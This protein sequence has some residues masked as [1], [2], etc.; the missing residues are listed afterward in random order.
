MPARQILPKSPKIPLCA[1]IVLSIALV[2]VL[3]VA[4]CDSQDFP[5]PNHEVVIGKIN[6]SGSQEWLITINDSIDNLASDVIQLPDENIAVA[7]STRNIE[8]MHLKGCNQH[9]RLIVI[10]KNGVQIVDEKET[11]EGYRSFTPYFIKSPQN[12]EIMFYESGIIWIFN[13]DSGK[14]LRRLQ[15]NRSIYSIFS[16]SENQYIG[17]SSTTV[18]KIDTNLNTVWKMSSVNQSIDTIQSVVEMSDKRGYLISG[19][20]RDENI[21]LTLYLLRLD[22]HGN[23]SSKTKV[24]NIE[25]FLWTTS[26]TPV[27]NGYELHYSGN[28]SYKSKKSLY[29][30]GYVYK[31]LNEIFL[32]RNGTI[33]GKRL[34]DIP[35][36]FIKTSPEEYVFTGFFEPE[37]DPN[38]FAESM[39]SKTEDN[40]LN[41]KLS[42][43]KSTS[44]GRVIWSSTISSPTIHTPVKI[45]QT[46]DN[47]FVFL[48]IR[49][50]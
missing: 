24:T 5:E 26:L 21:T 20:G 14:L 6:S 37:L 45:I 39:V 33:T 27:N 2:A 7:G 42:I 50:K 10:S 15:L 3:L 40:Q 12:N 35:E 46:S 19:Y 41:E 13:P 48:A 38:R 18:E 11:I 4:G 22:P 1:T 44:D 9:P 31:E 29:A 25:E 23:I 34:L 36:L 30:G 17:Y 47:G 8:C 43:R 49:N 28:L 16:T 32:D